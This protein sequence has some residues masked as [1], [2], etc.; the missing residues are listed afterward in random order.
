MCVYA[1]TPGDPT[2]HAEVVAIR[3]AGRRSD[4]D[5]LV[6][7]STL[8]YRRQSIPHGFGEKKLVQKYHEKWSIPT[9]T[10]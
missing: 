1:F 10:R 3:N 7:V 4:W 2:A 6:L 9:R 5:N 8:R